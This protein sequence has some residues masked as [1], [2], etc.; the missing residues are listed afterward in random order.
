MQQFDTINA[1]RAQRQAWL[2]AN[3]TL[4]FVPTMGNLHEGHL[5]LV[6]AAKAQ[7]DRVLVSIFINPLQFGAHE[8]L[9]RYPRTLDADLAKL[10]QLGVDAVFIPART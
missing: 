5:A 8:D 3:E 2:H 4:A 6:K 7:A 10:A 9:D 1:L